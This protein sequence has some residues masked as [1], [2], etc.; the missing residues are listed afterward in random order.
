MSPAEAAII[1]KIVLYDGNKRGW[2]SS[3]SLETNEYFIHDQS[4]DKMVT[5]ELPEGGIGVRGFWEVELTFTGE[6]APGYNGQVP[7]ADA[8]DTEEAGGDGADARELEFGRTAMDD[9]FDDIGEAPDGGATAAPAAASKSKPM[10]KSEEAASAE[11]DWEAEPFIPQS[12]SD[13]SD[14]LA[15]WWEDEIPADKDAE[16][17]LGPLW[18]APPG[19]AATSEAPEAVHDDTAAGFDEAQDG[20]TPLLPT[21]EEAAELAEQRGG[22]QQAWSEPAAGTQM[23]DDRPRAEAGTGGPSASSVDAAAAPVSAAGQEM[24]AAQQPPQTS[25]PEAPVPPPAQAPLQPERQVISGTVLDWCTKQEQFAHLPPLQEGWIRVVSKSTG[26]IYYLNTVTGQTTFTEPVAVT[27][28]PQATAPSSPGAPP[29]GGGQLPPGWS[30]VLS[31]S[32]GQYYYWNSVTGQA[33]F[34][35]PLG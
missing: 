31:K 20:E 35:P 1:G 27:A 22:E 21:R 23:A 11:V 25:A 18:A 5:E 30:R 2:V 7:E 29:G 10:R 14:G 33:Q 34:D 9:L 6:Y 4:T 16:V 3:V 28:G 15:T 26:G 24:A 32:T 17:D 19:E 8:E 13:P 12:V